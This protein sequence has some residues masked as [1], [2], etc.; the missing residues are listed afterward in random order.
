MPKRSDFIKLHL[1]LSLRFEAKA[2]S[3]FKRIITSTY[4]L[5]SQAYESGGQAEV[6]AVTK[7]HQEAIYYALA[8]TYQRVVPA[9]GKMV[10]GQIKSFKGEF[11]IKSPTL[12]SNQT[13]FFNDLATS[14]IIDQGLRES[15]L[16]SQSTL[17]DI[18]GVILDGLNNGLASREISKGILG[19]VDIARSRAR[20]I[21]IT[22]VHNA[23]MFASIETAKATGLTLQKEW[24]AVEDSR[25][26][27]SHQAA[28][29]QKVDMDGKFTVGGV[30]MDRPGDPSAPAREVINCRCACLYTEKDWNFTDG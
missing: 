6:R 12:S 3:V 7:S 17:D 20:T 11:E 8:T 10:L 23:S 21:A 18:N 9:Y 26:R 30:K 4:R 25:T 16:V 2:E 1:A 13:N 14:W 24:G 27:P 15:S 5:A 19:L 29:G 22:E 28:D